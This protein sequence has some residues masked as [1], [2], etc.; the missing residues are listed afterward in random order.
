ML[1]KGYAEAAQTL[2]QAAEI[3]GR[4]LDYEESICGAYE[5]AGRFD[6]AIVL[7]LDSLEAGLRSGQGFR[8]PEQIFDMAERSDNLA[9]LRQHVAA[10]LQKSSGAT[11][12]STG[13][14]QLALRTA[15][16]EADESL[17]NDALSKLIHLAQQR[18]AMSPRATLMPLA[19]QAEARQRL[20]DAIRLRQAIIDAAEAGGEAPQLDDYETLARLLLRKGEAGAAA[21]LMFAGL[22]RALEGDRPSPMDYDEVKFA[23]RQRR[24]RSDLAPAPPATVNVSNLRLAWIRG[25]FNII[26]EEHAAAG[27]EFQQACGDR[28]S[29]LV[30]EEMHALASNPRLYAGPLL[31]AGMERALALTERITAAFVQRCQ[32]PDAGADDHL[33]LAERLTSVASLPLDAAVQRPGFAEIAAAC[34]AAIEKADA[35]AKPAMAR[36]RCRIYRRL[37]DL[38]EAARLPDLTAETLLQAYETAIALSAN[39]LDLLQEAAQFARAQKHTERFLEWTRKRYQLAGGEASARAELAEALF[40]SGAAQEAVDL[41]RQGFDKHSAYTDYRA[42]AE[43]C[44]RQASAPEA[45]RSAVEFCQTAIR[46]YE[47]AAGAQIDAKGKP[48]P[49]D[50]LAS[51]YRLLAFAQA[52]CGKPDEAWQ[53]LL[54]FS[55][56]IT[57]PPLDDAAISAVAEAFAKANRR[58]DL[59]R[60][61]ASRVEA[62]PKSCHLRLLHANFLSGLGEYAAA[63]D[64]MRAARALHPDLAIVKRLI[65]LLRQSGDLR[66]ALSEAMAWAESFPRDA[67]V[68]QTMAEIYRDLKDDVGELRS[69]TMLVEVAPRDADNCR[70]VAAIFLE[71]GEAQRAVGLLERAIELRPE[72]PYRHIDLAEALWAAKEMARAETL[73]RESLT[74]DWEKGLSPELLERMPIWRGTFEHR[75]HALLAE[76]LEAQGKK[77]DAARER[78]QLPAG[79]KRPAFNDAVPAPQPRWRARGNLIGEERDR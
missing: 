4:R 30:E 69:L 32:K 48:L 76:I 58:D 54:A 56:R 70:R 35:M 9:F 42:A 23:R 39:N 13:L 74:R 66:M 49:D 16:H 31:S 79:Y 75:A 6:L 14:L 10:R 62:E 27:Q 78:M 15:W 17:A 50:E 47:Q 33:A 57:Q 61:I 37:F 51:L 36:S 19:V 3:T 20:A 46:L 44:W 45:A 18:H 1:D 55:S 12:P 26:A 22:S 5:M 60:L 67:D 2:A 77:D 63:A 11:L 40:A 28:V 38:P 73:C 34:S 8:S 43:I 25:I 59:L 68:Y 21:D 65:A 64:A 7:A 53:A 72:E 52:A 29:A 24:A 71:R 41:L